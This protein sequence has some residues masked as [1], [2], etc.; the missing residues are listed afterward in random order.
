MSPAV[1]RRILEQSGWT[2][3]ELSGHAGMS[4]ASVSEYLHGHRNPSLRQ[5]ERLAAAAGLEMQID[6]RASWHE[7]R[8]Q[9]LEDVLELSDRLPFRPIDPE[10]PPT[11]AELTRR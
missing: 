2:I 11:W 7:R 4:R 8:Q 10:G 1:V 5:L 6:V 9:E 3:T